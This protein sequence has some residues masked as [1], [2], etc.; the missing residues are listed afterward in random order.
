MSVTFHFASPKVGD[1]I[2]IKRCSV[3]L[4]VFA[5]LVS[6]SGAATVFPTLIATQVPNKREIETT[7]IAFTPTP[8]QGGDFASTAIM[9]ISP[10]TGV[11]ASVT[12]ASCPGP[13]FEISELS[14]PPI[15]LLVFGG[16]YTALRLDMPPDS[17]LFELPADPAKSYAASFSQDQKLIAYY[18]PQGK[19]SAGELWVSDVTLCHP[20]LIYTDDNGLI[21][22]SSSYAYFQ[23]GP[24]DKTVIF[25]SD[26]S[27]FP[28]LIYQ[29]E[30]QQVELWQGVCEDILYLDKTNEVVVGCSHNEKYSYLHQDGRVTT[31]DRIHEQAGATVVTWSFS[32]EG[33]AAYITSAHE[34]YLLQR[35]GKKI[36]LPLKG[37][38]P[39]NLWDPDPLHWAAEKN[40][41]LVLA[42]DPAEGRCPPDR[43]C[44]FVIDGQ[45]GEIIWWLRPEITE[46]QLYWNEIDT[47]HPAA[48]S[49][50][51]EL[52]AL[53][54]FQ[55]SLKYLLI[56]RVSTS[57][58]LTKA[59]V[60]S[61]Q[62]AW[63]RR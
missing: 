59:D 57:E 9:T 48:I 16:L 54:Y 33:N 28:M 63:P 15:F 50:D 43:A 47:T 52:L 25:R 35:N 45:S 8:P 42:Y 20:T 62:M 41:L 2:M 26:E 60:Y 44:W 13:W 46:S 29:L 3:F 17:L 7:P 14:I 49:S 6:C 39:F 24:G 37:F 22:E 30:N 4:L 53:Q 56:V 32:K 61:D 38:T 5:Q 23:W 18:L 58:V 19:S 34:V 21:N 55:T 36:K 11:I 27:E 1:E 51:G 31:A 10:T 12:P 40:R